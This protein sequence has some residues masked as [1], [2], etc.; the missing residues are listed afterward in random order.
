MNQKQF[1]N[2]DKTCFLC[3]QETENITNEDVFPLWLQR[4]Q[5]LFTE[6]IRLQNGTKFPY[7][8]IKVPC[9]SNCNNEY[10]SSIE[11]NVKGILK[12]NEYSDKD[13]D[14]LFS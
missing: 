9:C 7:K 2:I 14:V 1:Q 10:L 3:K 6:Y 12:N 11:N 4:K 5:K 8:K 13:K